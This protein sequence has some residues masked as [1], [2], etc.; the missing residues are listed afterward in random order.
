MSWKC[1]KHELR[2]HINVVMYRGHMMAA[3]SQ[4]ITIERASWSQCKCLYIRYVISNLWRQQQ[5][6][7]RQGGYPVWRWQGQ[8]HSRWAGLLVVRR[9]TASS[10]GSS[11]MKHFQDPGIKWQ[12]ERHEEDEWRRKYTDVQI[13]PLTYSYSHYTSLILTTLKFSIS[14]YLPF[15]SLCPHSVK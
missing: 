7:P 13:S 8:Q 3:I 12:G 5:P 9:R 6:Q 2:S 14:S 1:A 11:E 4:Y 10:G 15:L